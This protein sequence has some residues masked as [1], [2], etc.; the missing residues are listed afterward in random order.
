MRGSI[1]AGVDAD[2]RFTLAGV[3]VGEWVLAMNP[4]PTGYLKSAQFGGKDIRFTNF[5][6]GSN[7]E[8]QLDIVVSMNM[9][10]V[11]GQVEGASSGA[12]RSGIVLAPV[13]PLHDLARFYY[14]ATADDEGKFKLSEIAP[15]TYKIFALEKLASQNF[16]NP[17]AVDPLDK[18]GE[19]VE[20]KE[21]ATA[22]AH[23]RLI[24]YERASEALQ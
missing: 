7:T 8:A 6:V 12:R 14:G 4:A 15:G 19:L 17:E 5:E 9:G 16:R 13:G 1:S 20:V 10:V 21:G 2:G 3:S 18:L 22:P 11:E 23:P 24:P